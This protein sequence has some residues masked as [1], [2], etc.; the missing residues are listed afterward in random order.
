VQQAIRFAEGVTPRAGLWESKRG[1]ERRKP[2]YSLYAVPLRV[3]CVNE[4]VEV[5]GGPLR[6]P[7]RTL[8]RFWA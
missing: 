4:A 7:E 3:S 6:S 2:A 5:A 1:A 8:L